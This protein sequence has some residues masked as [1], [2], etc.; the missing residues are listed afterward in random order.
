MSFSKTDEEIINEYKEGNKEVFKLLIDRYTPPLFNFA[1][2]LIGKTDTADVIQEVFIKV[3]KKIN[4]FDQGKSSFKTWIFTI[5]KNAVIDFLRKKKSITFSALEN[6]EEELSFSENIPALEILPDEALQK[7]QDK[8]YLNAL[9]EKIVPEY[10]T[11]LILHYQEEMTF[12]EIGKILNKP[13]NTVKSYHYRA[14]K[15]LRENYK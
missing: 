6:Q 8:E 7:M 10:R 13:L 3:W 2:R 11:V 14:I 9:L 1:S 4:K 15:K 12:E 5:T